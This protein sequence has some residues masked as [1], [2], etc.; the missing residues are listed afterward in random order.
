MSFSKST[1]SL[2]RS[3]VLMTPYHTRLKLD[4]SCRD[5]FP[6]QNSK[7]PVFLICKKKKL[8]IFTSSILQKM[9]R[10]TR[11]PKKQTL[12]PTPITSK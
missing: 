10:K 4:W 2:K 1:S 12:S 3:P 11:S 9:L 7:L 8:R 5:F 6:S